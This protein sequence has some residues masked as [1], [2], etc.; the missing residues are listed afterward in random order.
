[1]YGGRLHVIP[2]QVP[3]ND[4]GNLARFAGLELDLDVPKRLYVLAP[5]YAF[6]GFELEDLLAIFIEARDLDAPCG[7]VLGIAG[8]QVGGR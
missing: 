6:G 7:G 8:K 3:G 4:E 1:M 2:T 5:A